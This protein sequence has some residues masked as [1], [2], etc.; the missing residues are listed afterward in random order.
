[1][2]DGNIRINVDLGQAL[3]QLQRLNGSLEKVDNQA[4]STNKKLTGLSSS[5]KSQTEHLREMRVAINRLLGESRSQGLTFSRLTGQ[6]QQ[7][8]TNYAEQT[9]AINSLIEKYDKLATAQNRVKESARSTADELLRV[10]TVFL[11]VASVASVMKKALDISVELDSMTKTF[12]AITGSMSGAAME[13][14]YVRDMSQQLGLDFMALTKSYKGF[15]AAT[16]FANMD[17]ATSKEIFESVAQAS[18][19]LGLSGQKTELVLMALEQMVSKGVVSMEELRRQLGDSL[20]GAFE[21]GAKAMGMT[22]QEFNKFVA[23]GKLMTDEFLPKFARTLKETYATVENVGLAVKTPRAEIQ[24][25]M[26]EL[27]FAMDAFSRYGFL[28]T[29]KRGVVELR[30][31]LQQEDVRNNIIALGKF[32]GNFADV[33]LQ[34]IKLALEYSDAIRILVPMLVVAKGTSLAFASALKI[35]AMYQETLAAKTRM[36]TASVGA[37][38][39]SWKKL[40]SAITI[41]SGAAKTFLSLGV[42]LAVVSIF[43]LLTR[44]KESSQEFDYTGEYAQKFGVSVDESRVQLEA[45]L[46]V[47]GKETPDALEKFE[48]VIA[49]VDV[50][51]RKMTDTAGNTIERIRDNWDAAAIMADRYA[52]VVDSMSDNDMSI[53]LYNLP[54]SGFGFDFKKTVSDDLNFAKRAIGDFV[55]QLKDGAFSSK[56]EILGA[57]GSLRTSLETNA[58]SVSDSWRQAFDVLMVNGVAV[59]DL[60]EQK[61][62]VLR[63]MNLASINSTWLDFNT[64]TADAVENLKAMTNV[65]GDMQLKF[66]TDFERD[67]KQLDAWVKLIQKYYDKSDEGIEK[68]NEA[69]RIIIK[70]TNLVAQLQLKAELAR[71]ESERK[72]TRESIENTKKRIAALMAEMAIMLAAGDLRGAAAK[73][74]M[75][76]AAQSSMA[77]L[78]AADAAYQA[79]IDAAMKRYE[80]VKNMGAAALTAFENEV[81]KKKDKNKPRPSGSN[82][83]ARRDQTY[84]QNFE[85]AVTDSRNAIEQLESKEAQ[86]RAQLQGD[87]F[88]AQIE[89]ISA[90]ATAEVAKLDSTVTDLENKLKG[91]HPGAQK[92]AAQEQLSIFKEQVEKQKELIDGNKKIE[93]QIIRIKQEMAKLKNE[94]ERNKQNGDFQGMYQ[95]EADRLKLELSQIGQDDPNRAAKEY[96]QLRAQAYANMELLFFLQDGIH[97]WVIDTQKELI[98]SFG[99]IIPDALDNTVD[100]FTNMFTDIITGSA[101][102]KD[103]WSVFTQAI[104]NMGKMIIQSLIKIAVQMMVVKAISGIGGLFGAADGAVVNLNGTVA[105]AA[106]TVSFGNGFA[107]GAASVAA[108]DG[109]V[110]GGGG[111]VIPFASGGILTSP[112]LFGT[113]SGDTVLAGEAGPEAFVPLGR[114]REGKLGVEIA[115]GGISGGGTPILVVNVFNNASDSVQTTQQSGTD[116]NGNPRLDVFI[117]QLDA[118]LAGKVQSGTSKLGA[119]IDKTRGTTTSKKLYA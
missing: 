31:A 27:T 119:A 52:D 56:K 44:L 35:Q 92:E 77:D 29:V 87:S 1:M 75:S 23:S 47:A 101:S 14:Q 95:N 5:M 103:A 9:K 22:L 55:K 113:K 20:P 58:S 36:T 61:L 53:D 50:K 54:T 49:N 30:E 21:L 98:D 108:A 105:N 67:S 74:S 117:D 32:F 46:R 83:A 99:Q 26:N 118:G 8:N 114:T 15:S 102:A 81:Q 94:A 71:I 18:T 10:S 40:G 93:Q 33:L 68:S 84:L 63:Q 85:K 86:L 34:V 111:R 80:E 109:R 41:A 88:A 65:S 104:T 28:D 116:Q 19:V 25:L 38:G 7:L 45:F 78:E 4:V 43:E 37:Q 62:S 13:M 3:Q 6:V 69:T 76:T 90:K 106:N 59:G 60:L 51:M 96:E 97:S 112:H 91:M 107:A 17:L 66:G 115:G 82:N 79:R 16:K 24:K 89:K 12:F 42:G 39:S 48:T 70:N 2:A 57:L 100:A 73:F 110:I 11:S 72:V 64:L